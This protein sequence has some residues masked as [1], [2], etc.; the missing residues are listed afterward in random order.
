MEY[1]PEPQ[2]I[3]ECIVRTLCVVCY[4]NYDFIQ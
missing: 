2:F 4:L 3:Q 1:Q